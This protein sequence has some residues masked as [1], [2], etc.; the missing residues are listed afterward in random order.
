MDSKL[1][2]KLFK[3]RNSI[4]PCLFL[5]LTNYSLAKGLCDFSVKKLTGAGLLGVDLA[6]SIALR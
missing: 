4:F 3:N 1:A 5:G 2:L 6:L